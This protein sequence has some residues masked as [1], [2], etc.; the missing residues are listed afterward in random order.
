M[1][2]VLCL[3]DLDFFEFI[4][5][6]LYFPVNVLTIYYNAKQVVA[7]PCK[8]TAILNNTSLETAVDVCELHGVTDGEIWLLAAPQCFLSRHDLIDFWPSFTTGGCQ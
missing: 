8:R 4:C 6:K 1:L 5:G 7:I 3:I 2:T